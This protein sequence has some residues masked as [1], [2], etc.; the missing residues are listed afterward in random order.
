MKKCCSFLDRIFNIKKLLKSYI[1]N[2]EEED[3]FKENKIIVIQRNSSNNFS[4]QGDF[5]N[6]ENYDL[7]ERFIKIPLVKIFIEEVFLPNKEIKPF[8]LEKIKG[9]Y[10]A[11]KKVLFELFDRLNLELNIPSEHFFLNSPSFY[12][13]GEPATGTDLDCYTPILFMEF[14]IYGKTFVKNSKLKTINLVHNIEYTN[15]QYTQERAGC[16]EYEQTKSI[17][18]AVHERNLAYIRIVLHHEYFHFIDMEEDFNY[19]D[20]DWKDIN[21]KGF[22]YG[23]GGD[24]ER[25]W[26]KLGKDQKGFINHY[27]TTAL[28]EDRAEIYQYLIS[29]PDEALNNKDIIVSKKAERIKEFINDFDPEGFG[30]PENNFWSNLIDYRKAYVY[31]EKVYQGNIFK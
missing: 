7:F 19:E 14:W 3:M 21:I 12:L 6:L 30:D 23:K 28:E 11:I 20:D 4:P 9:I 2:D 25:E 1:L 16:P 13:E 10:K 18:F 8:Q 24:S 22:K 31:K 15:S 27:S 5:S 26:V 29:C 17:T